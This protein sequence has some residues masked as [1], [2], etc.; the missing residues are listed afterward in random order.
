MEIL[1]LKSDAIR[2]NKTREISKDVFL[3]KY[4]GID[5]IE[6]D[7]SLFT[8]ALAQYEGVKPEEILFTD[9]IVK[10][11]FEDDKDIIDRI[12]EINNSK[13]CFYMATASDLKKSSAIFIQEQYYPFGQ[14]LKEQATGGVEHILK[15][16]DKVTIMKETA[17][18]GFIF[19]GAQKTNI[20]PKVVI[21]EEPKYI[22]RGTHSVLEG[23]E[24]AE[25]IDDINLVE[26]EIETTLSA[27]DGQGIMSKSLADRIA[28]DL[29]IDYD[30]TWITFRLYAGIGG[31]GVATTVNIYEELL[32][33]HKRYGDTVHLKMVD[34][35]LMIRD[36]WNRYHKVS[37]VDM[38]LNQSQ[39]KL[40][41]H[42]DAEY[43]DNVFNQ[44]DDIFKCLYVCKYN[45]KKLRSD[46]TK[47]NYQFLQA[48]N[49]SYEE[50][51]EITKHDREHLDASLTDIDS[52]LITTNLTDIIYEDDDEED[53]EIKNKF[54]LM[55]ELVKYDSSLLKDWSVQKEMQK[56]LK[57]RINKVSYGKVTLNDSAYRLIIQDVQVYMNFIATRDMNTARNESCL[58][59]GEYYSVGRP[60]GQKTVMGRNPLS[61]SQEL[62][63][64]KNKK[65][66]YI[67][68]L[69]YN[70]DSILVMNTYD[71]TAS[72][73]SGAD[74]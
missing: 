45:P 52:L 66:G 53:K 74:L 25:T 49:L 20:I 63:K 16:K 7:E 48:L 33:V 54:N 2:I 1:R 12:I 41:K 34:N 19:S 57:S 40:V 59:A 14:W 18:Q 24:T 13:Y 15:E 70:C 50:L 36:I 69:N 6:L 22:Y 67:D 28:K 9:A 47:L 43:L 17:Y 37:E 11:E 73:M 35:K 29:N 61:S 4:K 32:E 65:N 8:V 71:A 44:V 42:F 56:L 64:F 55:L 30:L 27:F 39:C 31:K 26:K 62:V 46:R 23:V 58:Q 5:K 10:V 38:I 60:D 68:S 72:R 3:D 51:M 21:I